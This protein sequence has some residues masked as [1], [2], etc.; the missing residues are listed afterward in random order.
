MKYIFL[1]FRIGLFPLLIVVLISCK[2]E[3][4]YL[5][6][7]IT[8]YVKYNENAIWVIED[9]INTTY[10]TLYLESQST[11]FQD[12]NGG[13]EYEY[14][15][16]SFRL[17]RF[18]ST[19]YSLLG[20][21]NARDK[22]YNLYFPNNDSIY[23]S[24]HSF[25]Y[26]SDYSAGLLS[27]TCEYPVLTVNGTQYNNVVFASFCDENNGDTLKYWWIKNNGLIR[28]ECVSNGGL[29]KNVYKLNKIN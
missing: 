23:F 28:S 12:N 13:Y 21:C 5:D 1:K 3:T 9:S 26:L 29:Q 22:I 19:Q 20:R 27:F 10:D 4:V 24:N 6:S 8:D 14:L 17:S 7:R 16:Q 25:G 2:E 11:Y 18:N 15:E